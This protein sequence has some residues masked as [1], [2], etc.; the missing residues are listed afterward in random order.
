MNIPVFISVLVCNVLLCAGL[1]IALKDSVHI[2]E[3]FPLA[4]I[5]IL[6][7]LF[8]ALFRVD[9]LGISILYFAFILSLLKEI[10][11]KEIIENPFV[12]LKA[13][14]FLVLIVLI[15]KGIFMIF[16]ENDDLKDQENKN[17]ND[18][19]LKE[20]ND[21]PV[22]KEKENQK[23]SAFNQLFGELN[24]MEEE[25]AKVPKPK[26]ERETIPLKQNQGMES[27]KTTSVEKTEQSVK[28]QGEINFFF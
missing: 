26:T 24:S 25:E 3:K 11:S 17:S 4:C 13:F 19:S 20:I 15:I 14:G 9:F 28:Q 16:N 21:E 10:G 22:F 6:L 27:K 8:F 2:F 5:L 7:S 1:K 12:I 23:Q 18:L